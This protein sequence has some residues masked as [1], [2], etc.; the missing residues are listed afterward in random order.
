MQVLVDTSVWSLALRRRKNSLSIS[1]ETLVARLSDLIG[2]GRVLLLGAV[3]Q[4][5]LSGVK[6]AEQFEA[7]RAA[8]AAFPDL[9][10]TQSDYERAADCFNRCRARGIQGANTDFL[11]CAVAIERGLPLFSTD[12]DFELIAS[13]LPLSLYPTASPPDDLPNGRR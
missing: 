3:R 13:V 2:D 10:L 1:E 5:L 9:P 12:R 8:L 6:L 11:L 7:L 4:E